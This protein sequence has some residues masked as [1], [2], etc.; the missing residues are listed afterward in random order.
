VK[1]A[2]GHARTVLG[3]AAVGLAG[4]RIAVVLIRL[5]GA[6]GTIDAV[7]NALG[8]GD[9]VAPF[10]AWF[11]AWVTHPAMEM[12]GLTPT[13]IPEPEPRPL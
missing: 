5:A 4:I 12:I 8:W 7:A 10:E 3:W 2:I 9:V 6:V 1:R 13:P 11:D